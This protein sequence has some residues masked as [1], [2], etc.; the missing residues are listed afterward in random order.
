MVDLQE[1]WV[2][3]MEL[4]RRNVSRIW[5]DLQ[6]QLAWTYPRLWAWRQQKFRYLPKVWYALSRK[7]WWIRRLLIRIRILRAWKIQIL[8]AWKIHKTSLIIWQII[9]E[10]LCFNLLTSFLHSINIFIFLNTRKILKTLTK[11]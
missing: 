10:I 4:Q 1:W 9:K 3:R 7:I 6:Q 8:W 2:L 5:Q 11:I